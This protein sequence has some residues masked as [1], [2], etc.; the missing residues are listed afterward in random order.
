ML[1]LIGSYDGLLA[2]LLSL[3]PNL[4]DLIVA[5]ARTELI[6]AAFGRDAH[7]VTPAAARMPA[8][9]ARPAPGP[10]RA[11]R[12][13]PA[14]KPPVRPA[15]PPPPPPEDEDP[16]VRSY[17]PSEDPGQGI[18]FDT[19]RGE[20]GVR[21]SFGEPQGVAILTISLGEEST[22]IRESYPPNVRTRE[23]IAK[24][25]AEMLEPDENG[26]PK[27]GQPGGAFLAA[28]HEVAATAV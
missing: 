19:S 18:T 8:T 24:K 27:R 6:L 14:P 7:T 13:P 12:Q 17:Q 11:Q 9:G 16:G 22:K 21:V 25:I 15:A 1:L 10:Q 5:K 23:G 4:T 3:N 26:Q 28:L 20:L 2:D